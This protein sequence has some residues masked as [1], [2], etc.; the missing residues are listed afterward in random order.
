MK[1]LLLIGLIAVPLAFAATDAKDD[2]IKL[3]KEWGM[4]NLKGDEA[5][6]GKIYADGLFAVTPGGVFT[7][8]DMLD[9]AQASDDTNYVT[10]DYKVEMLGDDIAV[11]AHD[12]D[13]YR[14]LHVFQQQGGA[15]KVVATATVPQ[16]QSSS[17]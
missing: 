1:K 5:A 6:L 10:S 9:N 4:A 11:M 12:A 17:D 2:L 8:A 16:A 7:R 15:W 13:G 14:S 3:D